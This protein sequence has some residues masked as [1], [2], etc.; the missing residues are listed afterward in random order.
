M[1]GSRNFPA[2]MRSVISHVPTWRCCPTINEFSAT[3]PSRI[4]GSATRLCR[5]IKRNLNASYTPS[6]RDAPQGPR[7]RARQPPRCARGRAGRPA[8]EPVAALGTRAKLLLKSA[9]FIEALRSAQS[10][11]SECPD[12]PYL[13]ELTALAYSGLR[14]PVNARRVFRQGIEA[15]KQSESLARAYAFWSMARGNDREAVATVRRLTRSAP[16]LKR[17]SGTS[18]AR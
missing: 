3:T 10:A 11:S 16:A 18:F 12:Q 5:K 17:F 1:I 4:I 13:W 8:G 7:R 6:R 2:S 9:K 14:D 15:N